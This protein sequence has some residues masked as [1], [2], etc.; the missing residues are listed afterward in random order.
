V[1]GL[2]AWGG[3]GQTARGGSGQE[4][5]KSSWTLP[6]WNPLMDQAKPHAGGG[7]GSN[8]PML[9]HIFQHKHLDVHL[10]TTGSKA[11]LRS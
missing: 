7:S 3:G 8:V 5:L 9:Q 1:G 4:T 6:G 2:T 11:K 10:F